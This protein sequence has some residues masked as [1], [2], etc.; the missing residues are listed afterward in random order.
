MYL[1]NGKSKNPGALGSRVEATF[2]HRF[3]I[4]CQP[5]ALHIARLPFG[6]VSWGNQPLKSALFNRFVLHTLAAWSR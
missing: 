3:V 2:Q 1:M 4:L 5:P 6:L